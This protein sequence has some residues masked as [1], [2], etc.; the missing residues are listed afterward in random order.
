MSLCV[1]GSVGGDTALQQHSS[2]LVSP[3]HPSEARPLLVESAAM[4]RGAVCACVAVC[5]LSCLFLRSMKGRLRSASERVI[6]SSVLCRCSS[7]KL[8]PLLF[9]SFFFFFFLLVC[10][11]MEEGV[12]SPHPMPV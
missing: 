5:F 8:S 7:S 4:V 3:A 2:T 6:L 11:F 1:D 12:P 10:L 9:S